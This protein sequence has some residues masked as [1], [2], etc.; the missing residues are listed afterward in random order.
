MDVGK[1][2]PATIPLVIVENMLIEVGLGH[3][4]AETLP[5][6]IVEQWLM[7]KVEVDTGLQPATI[8]LITKLNRKYC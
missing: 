1:I 8:P 7:L 4:R 2:L 3:R 5:L 6:T